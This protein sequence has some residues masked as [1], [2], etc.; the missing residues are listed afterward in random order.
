MRSLRP[1]LGLALIVA[2]HFAHAMSADLVVVVKADSRVE[3]LTREQVS[4]IFLGRYRSLP[5]G[6][7]AIP[8]DNELAMTDFY[9]TLVGRSPADIGAYWARLRFS[10]G[11]KPPER[12]SEAEALKTVASVPGAITYVDR[13]RIDERVRV[14]LELAP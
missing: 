14:I 1:Q 10:G 6:D 7:R 2:F 11:M 9:K 3:H 12:M 13:K 8:L 4:D 5:G